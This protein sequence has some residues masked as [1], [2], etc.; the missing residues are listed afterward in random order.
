MFS[1]DIFNIFEIYVFQ[2]DATQESAISG[3]L[4]FRRVFLWNESN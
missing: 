4:S 2:F 3:P 1:G